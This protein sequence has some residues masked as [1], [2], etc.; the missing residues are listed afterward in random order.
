M[1]T[2][3]MNNVKQAHFFFKLSIGIY[4]YKRNPGA[5][6]SRQQSNRETNTF[7]TSTG[8]YV[9]FFDVKT[10]TYILYIGCFLPMFIK[11]WLYLILSKRIQFF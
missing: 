1:C 4:A 9:K 10:D 5:Y 6:V 8:K 3:N 2:K 7:G 11:S